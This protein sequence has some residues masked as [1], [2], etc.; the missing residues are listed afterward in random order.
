MIEI[1]TEGICAEHNTSTGG[2]VL[3]YTV[4]CRDRNGKEIIV[5]CFEKPQYILRLGKVIPLLPKPIREALKEKGATAVK[6]RKTT[7]KDETKV[8]TDI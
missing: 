8:D 5:G 6:V 2:P 1:A 4:S 3:T 7:D